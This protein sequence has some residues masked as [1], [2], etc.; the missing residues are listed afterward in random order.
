MRSAT[1]QLSRNVPD[2]TCSLQKSLANATISISPS[3]I[4]AAL[5]LS[6][7]P[8]PSQNPAPTATIFWPQSNRNVTAECRF[9]FMNLIK[10]DQF[11]RTFKAPHSSTVSLSGTTVMRK[12]G[13][14][15][16]SLKMRPFP[17]FFAPALTGKGILEKRDRQK[18]RSSNGTN[19]RQAS[20]RWL[21]HRTSRL[22]PRWRCWPPLGR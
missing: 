10:C 12:L 15:I 11:E 4:T 18:K 16:S 6:P 1:P 5:V 19:K 13:V 20:N 17:S 14:C 2:L 3:R 22:P 7:K 9:F 8:R 21:F